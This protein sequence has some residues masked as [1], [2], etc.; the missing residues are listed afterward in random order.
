MKGEH[1]LQL[2]NCR[3]ALCKI[4]F[5]VGNYVALFYFSLTNAKSVTEITINVDVL[6]SHDLIPV[7]VLD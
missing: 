7:F 6:K 1:I 3:K 5:N 2:E 4:I